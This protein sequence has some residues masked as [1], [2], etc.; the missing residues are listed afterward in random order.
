MLTFTEIIHGEV[1]DNMATRALN[2]VNWVSRWMARRWLAWREKTRKRD[3]V[4]VPLVTLTD[5][6]FKDDICIV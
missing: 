1:V 4:N 3:R 2:Q 5:W 6:A